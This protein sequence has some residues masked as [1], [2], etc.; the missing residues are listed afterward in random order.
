MSM[1]A[2][3]FDLRVSIDVGLTV[4][5]AILAVLFAFVARAPDILYD[6]YVTASQKGNSKKKKKGPE[7]RLS[8]MQACSMADEE[9]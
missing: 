5:S 2:Y 3:S 1:L 6:R 9:S 7:R 8:E 4:L